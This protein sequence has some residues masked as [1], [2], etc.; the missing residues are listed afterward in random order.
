MAVRKGLDRSSVGTGSLFFF[1]V[2]ASA[3][4]T[5]LAGGMV[6]TYAS[7]GVLGVPLSFLVLG[8][9]LALFTVGYMAM[10][11]RVNHA[12]TFFAF[13]ARGLGGVA[14]LSGGVVAFAAYNC[15]QISLYG[16]LGVTI[17]GLVGGPWWIWAYLALAIVALFGVLR[18]TVN[19]KVLATLLICEI[20]MIVLFD[21][22]SFT[23]AHDGFNLRPLAPHNL[24]VNGLGG[25]F[26]LG[27]AAFVGYESGP[28][29]GEEARTRLVVSRA[30][31]WG[32]AFITLFYT[33]SAWA[34][35]EAAGTS[36]VGSGA[37][38]VAGVVAAARDPQ[39]GLPFNILQQQF[40][41][42]ASGPA[43]LLLIT[44]VF[45]ALLSFHNTVAR[46]VFGM[47]RD[48]VL[49]SALGRVG[50]GSRAGAPI[51]GSVVQSVI[52]F[53]VVSLFLVAKADPFTQLFT[54]LS[55]IAA[56]GLLLV[57]VG[58]CLATLRFF[59][60]QREDTTQLW[61]GQVAPLLGALALTIVLIVTVANLSALLGTAPGSAMTF[62]LPAIVV[63]LA[64]AGAVW[65]LFLRLQRPQ[66]YRTIGAGET[67][68][69]SVLSHSYADIA[70]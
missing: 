69:L 22:T 20:A 19:A 28:V 24:F 59:G 15:I 18:I 49:P 33:I 35:A 43:K 36:L 1:V 10:A 23:H 52:A 11:Q 55:T 9:A 6:A 66:V 60:R 25:V 65:G 46:Y 40:G 57:M 32:L 16:L 56:I 30:S 64:V 42:L 62:L 3:P 21:I 26:A 4:M 2:G 27:V 34:M 41:G 38:A 31:Y 8:A 53:L 5:V 67:K 58:T 47:A 48:R 39:S 37:D 63:V 68:P 54:W 61:Q 70:I 12:A 14:G 17:S 13:L 51:G 29:Y 44:S 7:T 50:T 45:A